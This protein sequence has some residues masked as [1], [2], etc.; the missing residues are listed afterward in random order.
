[1][2]SPRIIIV[3][4]GPAGIRCAETL[5]ESGLRPIVIDEHRQSGGQIYK[6]QPP[7]FRRGYRTLYG[8]E[9]RKAKAI[10]S[11][12]DRLKSRIDY[13][14]ETTVWAIQ[15]KVLYAHQQ[16]QPLEFH[17]DQII[18]C[19]GA[20]DRVLPIPGWENAGTYTLGGAQM[21]L[22]HQAMS[23]GRQIVFTGTGPLL[24]LVAYQYFK[25]GANV[26][27][28]LDTSSFIQRLK[29]LP[30][31]LTKPTAIF[32]GLR[33][34]A[35]LIAANVK[36]RTGITPLLIAGDTTGVTQF[37]FRDGKGRQ[38]KLDCDAIALGFHLRPE[39][40]IADLAGCEFKYDALTRL[41]YPDTDWQGRTSVSH[42]YCAGDGS[43]I[44]G[45]DAAECA[46]QLA[47]LALLTDLRG[48]EAKRQRRLKILHRRMKRLTIFGLGLQKAFPWPYH[49][50]EKMDDATIVCRC[51]MISAAE[52][53]QSVHA[54]A[55]G[56][57]NRA[58]SFSR[59]GMGRCQGRYCAHINAEL[60][61][62][63]K[64]HPLSQSGRQR[65]QAPVK[66]LAVNLYLRSPRVI[67]QSTQTEEESR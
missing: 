33:M 50:I 35:R 2:A 46:G 16:A 9:H 59:A 66:P 62:A 5:V 52:V 29:A 18:L 15:D 11:D 65:S 36:L 48:P 17:F 26:A 19:T 20:T 54:K 4:A 39:T 53:R 63:E 57:V 32:Y 6:R 42:V 24:Y 60:I 45:A 28:V 51:E 37:H 12:F 14:P 58:K 34:M 22:K 31:L 13:Y 47:A 7:M 61:A 43:R 25:A 64:R 67:A 55:A 10:H 49:L 27:A 23:I 38:Q 40:Q 3:G 41:W 21:A 30:H 8:T 44:L 56:E 1:M